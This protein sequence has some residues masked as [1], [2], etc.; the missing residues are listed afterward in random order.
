MVELKENKLAEPVAK[1]LKAKGYTVYCEVSPPL[2]TGYF[3]DIVGVR[4]K[5]IIAIELKMSLTRNVICQANR[6]HLFAHKTYVAVASK[7]RKTSIERCKSGIN[8]GVLQVLNGTVTEHHIPKLEKPFDEYTT[9]L[10]RRL[11]ITIP[12]YSEAGKPTLPETGAN[13]AVYELIREYLQIHPSANWKELYREVPNHYASVGSMQTSMRI[14][15]GFRL[16]RRGKC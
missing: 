6:H 12:G 11:T 7:P 3:V 5:F 13:K 8:L 15:Q 14:R 4:G 10:I 16:K 9:E 1:W 2:A